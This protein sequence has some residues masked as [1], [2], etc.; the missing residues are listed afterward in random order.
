MNL[1]PLF[2]TS[3]KINSLHNYYLLVDDDFDDALVFEDVLKEVDEKVNFAHASNGKEALDFLNNQEG[4]LP[5]LIFLDLNMPRM[6]GKE[7][8]REI[9]TNHKY[10]HIPVLI[11]TTSSQSSDIEETIVMGATC[12]ITKPT[13]I[14]ELKKILSTIRFA[15]KPELA[16]AL[17][18][19]TGVNS[20][21]VC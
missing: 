16:K 4:N 14:R 19:L 7:T 18:G 13:A 8:L 12:F 2:F 21:I 9:K 10:R 6:N 15:P 17:R 5:E 3:I 11:Y 1:S 20:F